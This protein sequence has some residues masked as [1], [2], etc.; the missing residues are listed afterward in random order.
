MQLLEGVKVIDFSKWLP[1]QYCGMLLGDYGADVIKIEDLQGDATRNFFPAKDKG[2][3]YW[4]MML[5][6]NKRTVALDFKKPAGKELLLR[7][8]GEADVFLEGFRPGYLARYGLGYEDIKA[9]NPGIIYVSITGFGQNSHKP[10]HDLNVIGLAGL[11]SLD[12]VG[13]A[14]VSEVQVSAVG[15]GINALS[16]ICMSLFA[17]E[18]SKVG[19]H[20]DV[21]LYATA[22]S[23]Q[24]TAAASR[25]GA[26]ETGLEEFGRIAHYYNIYQCKDG[27]FLTVGTIE[28]KFWARFC[29][30]IERPDLVGRQYDFAHGKELQELL[31]A[32]IMEKTQAEWLELI[33]E[34]E[35]CVTPVLSLDEA[36][37]SQLTEQE[38]ILF[39]GDCDLGVL[40]Y[41]GAPV[42]FSGAERKEPARAAYLGEYT[43]E[44]MQELGYDLAAIEQM[45]KAGAVLCKE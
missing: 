37:A 12:D 45:Q 39:E 33:G 38:D 24:V 9:I 27:K 32:K 41:L 42:K 22:L 2:M 3:S 35:I 6:R 40:R 23:M 31:A 25:W 34:E 18:R 10:A 16:G 44:V 21:N 15:S 26:Q 4:H 36:L 14:C 5:N 1:G 20:L 19:Q 17:R 8:L 11:N 13:S 43:K 29:S 30:F 28:P 7:L